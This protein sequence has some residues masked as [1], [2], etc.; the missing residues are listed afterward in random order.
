MSKAK[1][2][3]FYHSLEGEQWKEI[4]GFSGYQV[5]NKGRI[6]SCKQG[7]EK[8]LRGTRSAYGYQQVGLY[9]VNHKLHTQYVH[10]LVASFFI[11]PC[12]AGKEV[13]HIDL[14]KFHNDVSNLEYVTDQEQ[15][16]HN[17][18]TGNLADV[19]FGVNHHNA[20]LTE[21][22]ARQ[23]FYDSRSNRK[24]AVAFGVSSQTI[25]DLKNRKSWKHLKL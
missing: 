22:T 23:A 17:V 10:I 18:K 1:P 25:D 5:S 16:Q 19:P 14:N 24:I 13:N 2:A 9:D 11:G 20:K 4:T 6:R 7:K 8:L 12:P 21:E 3:I 15:I